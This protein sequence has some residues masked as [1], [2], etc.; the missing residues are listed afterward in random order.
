VDDAVAPLPE[1]IERLPLAAVSY[2]RAETA[3]Q[4]LGALV[5]ALIAASILPSP[6]K[7]LVLLAAVVGGIAAIVAVPRLRHRRWRYAVRDTEI[8]IRHG[9]FVVRRTVVP[10][11]RVQHVETESGPVQ[12][13]FEVASVAFFT[14]AGKTEIPAL[15][16]G[17]AEL[18]RARIARLARTLHDV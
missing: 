8:D 15:G 4:A 18:V 2:W 7:W 6:W 14:A 5:A 17:Q 3:L 9:M 10:I 11:R 12:S 1:P 13:L 16:R